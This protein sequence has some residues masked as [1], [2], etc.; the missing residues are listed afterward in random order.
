MSGRTSLRSLVTAL[1]LAILPAVAQADV[2]ELRNGQ[3]VEG[4]LASANSRSVTIESG[5]R[6]LTFD[7]REVRAILFGPAPVAAAPVPAGPSPARQAVRA[8]R[9]LQAMTASNP[10]PT[11]GDY[12][13]RVGETRSAVDRYLAD[14]GNPTSASARPAIEE[15]MALHTLGS[16]AWTAK[17]A[18]R[19]FEQ[20]GKEAADIQCARLQ[21]ELRTTKQDDW[22]GKG[23]LV[24]GW[25][26][27]LI[28]S[29][30]GEKV[31][32]AERRLGPEP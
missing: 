9:A 27:P 19:G 10:P 20:V 14:P 2:V 11:H 17:L 28:W 8:L 6:M 15:A 21:A 25:G 30:A 3:K 12:V 13:A 32:E 26:M 4:T 18:G 16:A 24:A 7:A 22:L 5:G 31:T 29:C 23:F 1:T